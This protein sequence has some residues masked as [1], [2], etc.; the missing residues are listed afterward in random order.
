MN[1]QLLLLRVA[2][3][4]RN[5]SENRI[6]ERCGEQP[7]WHRTPYR[8]PIHLLTAVPTL[9]ESDDRNYLEGLGLEWS[10]RPDLNG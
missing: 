6:A 4:L 10:R 5:S 1:H 3:F 8:V 7:K 9:I 2:E